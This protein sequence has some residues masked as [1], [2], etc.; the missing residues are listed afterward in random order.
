PGGVRE[1]GSS[2]RRRRGRDLRTDDGQEVEDVGEDGPAP[3]GEERG[4]QEGGPT[5]TGE[6]ANREPTEPGE[7]RGEPGRGAGAERTPEPRRDLL[8][9]RGPEARGEREGRTSPH[10][11]ER[12]V[13]SL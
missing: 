1:G 4:L 12:R 11:Q 3:Q 2:G 7:R 10:P 9:E 8:R 5:P 13:M 6:A